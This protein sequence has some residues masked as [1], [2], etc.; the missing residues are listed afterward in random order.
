MWGP[1]TRSSARQRAQNRDSG[2]LGGDEENSGV[3]TVIES[4]AYVEDNAH[5]LTFI[6]TFLA[7]VTEQQE[8]RRELTTVNAVV[9]AALLTKGPRVPKD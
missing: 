9:Q 5:W 7:G 4:S 6:H 1:A 2:A 8:E 3:Y